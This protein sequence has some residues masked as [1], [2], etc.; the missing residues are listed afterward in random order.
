MNENLIKSLKTVMQKN[1]L[2]AMFVS[3]PRNVKYL[4]GFKTTLPGDVQSFGDPEG[5]V[6]AHDQR[7]DFLCD[8][9]YINAVRQMPGV[10]AQLLESPVTPARI[11]A[12]VKELLPGGVTNLGFERDAVV[13]ADAVEFIDSLP[14]L[15][16]KPA[17]SVFAELRLLK[18][19]DEIA[20]MRKAEAITSD[21]YHHAIKVIRAG[22]TERDLALEIDNYLRSHSEG[23]SFETIVAFGE[24]SCNP[25]YVPDPK[26]KLKKGQLVLMDFGSI[27]HGYCGDMTRCVCF[28]KSDERQREVYNIVL[29]AQ[30]AGLAAV[31]PGA[32]AHDIDQAVR[33][34]F[35]KHDCLDKF[36]HGTGHG[37]GLAVHE[38]PRIKSGFE[39]IIE[40]GMIFSVEPGLY[41]AGWG[42]VRIEDL[43]VVT[44]DGYANLT[45]APKK[46]LVEVGGSVPTSRPATKKKAVAKKKSPAKKKPA[47]KKA[48]RK[49]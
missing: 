29:E 17:E 19:P 48:A 26:R 4:T 41:Y 22:M 3:N 12:K 45:K 13:H 36:L 40:P 24:T 7:V 8:G 44:E 15:T 25:H 30:L 5:F 23:C 39:T 20:L 43:V 32:K 27:Y 38:A 49:R 14:S 37:I 16:L 11:A 2:E 9:R 42:G 1:G 47:A 21:C 6:L 35:E 31:R 33:K 46:Q 10:T 18:S 28:G 34:V